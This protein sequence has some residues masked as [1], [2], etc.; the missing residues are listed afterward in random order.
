MLN[1][2]EV[3]NQRCHRRNSHRRVYR[4]DPT[5]TQKSACLWC[6]FESLIP[7]HFHVGDNGK[8]QRVCFSEYGE[9]DEGTSNVASPNIVRNAI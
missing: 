9:C 7:Y 4:Y 1:P 6:R 5:G 2:G 8:P 3:V